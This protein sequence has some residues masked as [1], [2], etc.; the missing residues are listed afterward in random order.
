MFA[1]TTTTNVQK[2]SL[3]NFRRKKSHVLLQAAVV[4]DLSMAGWQTKV[5]KD[6]EQRTAFFFLFRS[7][8]NYFNLRA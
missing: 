5:V 4:T 1:S 6:I 8:V 7:I 2:Q 3:P